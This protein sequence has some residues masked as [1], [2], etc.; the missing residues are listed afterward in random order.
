[1]PF[2]SIISFVLVIL[3][4]VSIHELG[5]Y[6]IAIKSGIKVAEFS[7]GFG[8]SIYSKQLKN[9]TMFHVRS[10]PFGG[11][12][13]MSEEESKEIKPSKNILKSSSGSNFSDK[14]NIIK[15]LVALGG[16]IANYVL[17]LFLFFI[18]FSFKGIAGAPE[19]VIVNKVVEAKASANINKLHKDDKITAIGGTKINS[20]NELHEIIASSKGKEIKIEYTRDGQAQQI[21]TTP[22]S[23]NG[24][25]T[26]GLSLIEK[27]SFIKL[28][29]YDSLVKSATY[30]NQL[31]IGSIQGL[32]GII[33]GTH[34]K[35]NLGGPIKIAQFAGIY[36]QQGFFTF[37][38]FIATLSASLFL[39]NLLPIP[40][41]DGGQIL[42]YAVELIIGR[43]MH[44]IFYKAFQILGTLSILFLMAFTLLN[45]II[46][47]FIKK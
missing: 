20:L 27:K 47:I 8:S 3:I 32:I 7:I 14:S 42:F 26:I 46:S 15:I 33:K 5:H 29:Y 2:L 28:G 35:A 43:P 38:T 6:I 36:M 34:S 17:A 11:Y 39:L 4:T 9:G 13:K 45:D 41:L 40:A 24:K 23:K 10:L 1:M 21:H 16:P 25:Y 44:V 31:T 19:S 37:L 18:V 30:I 22:I 12:V